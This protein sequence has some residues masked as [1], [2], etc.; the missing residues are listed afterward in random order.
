MKIE[1]TGYIENGVLK[2]ANRK[3][4][5]QDLKDFKNCDVNVIIKKKGKRSLPQLRYYFG[6]IVHEIQ[7]EFRRRG[8]RMDAE[9]VHEFLK[10]HF[11]KQYVHNEFGEVIAEYG[12]STTEFNKEQMMEYIDRIIIWCAEKLSITIPE[13]NKQA[14]MFN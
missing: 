13:A 1:H 4:L 12:G 11:N 10:L 14:E 2:I 8:I 6:V 9:Q 5:E 3:R 7:T